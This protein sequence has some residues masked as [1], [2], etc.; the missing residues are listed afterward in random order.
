MLLECELIP[1]VAER[2]VVLTYV[3][4]ILD[5][6]G[7]LQ[8]LAFKGGTCLKKIYY[9]RVTRF[10]EELNFTSL[11]SDDPNRFTRKLAETFD[12]KEYYD[13]TFKIK[14]QDLKEEGTTVSYRAIIEYEHE[15][16]K[17]TFR[18]DI[19]YREKPALVVT[20]CR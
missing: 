13:I 4:K 9:A 17:A 2:D 6:V 12:A 8:K 20:P 15:W 19:S 11:D 7:L 16:N 5:D 3:L 1:F 10:S 18:L 14:D